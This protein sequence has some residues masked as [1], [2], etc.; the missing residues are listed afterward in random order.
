[1]LLIVYQ[2]LQLRISRTHSSIEEDIRAT[3]FLLRSAIVTRDA[4][5]FST[6]TSEADDQWL[7]EQTQLLERG[8]ILDRPLMGLFVLDDPPDIKEINI[9]DDRRSAQ[10][11]VEDRYRVG[12]AELAQELVVLQR[13]D[14][15]RW[16]KGWLWAPPPDDYWGKRINHS[17]SDQQLTVE[18][19][20]RD[21]DLVLRLISDLEILFNELCNTEAYVDCS[22]VYPFQLELSQDTGRFLELS[23]HFSKNGSAVE[24]DI[25]R[26]YGLSIVLP[27]PTLIG[28]PI[29]DSGYQALLRTYGIHLASALLSAAGKYECCDSVEEFNAARQVFLSDHD[30]LVWPDLE[31][32]PLPPSFQL[33][34]SSV[35]VMCSSGFDSGAA[36][37][38]YDPISGHWVL[39]GRHP[40]DGI[41]RS[42]PGGNGYVVQ[43][44]QPSGDGIITRL[45]F[46]E[47]EKERVLFNR[48]LSPRVAEGF[49]WAV[50]ENSD[51]LITRIPNENLG[52]ANYITSDLICEM[53]ECQ[54]TEIELQGYPL[55]SP[56]DENLIVRGY[57]MFWLHTGVGHQ[58]IAQQ[59]F[60]QAPFWIDDETFGYVR[61]NTGVRWEVA[62]SSI[63]SDSHQ[64]AFNSNDSEAL[65]PDEQK[66]ARVSIALIMPARE[67]ED[68]WWV[69]AIAQPYREAKEIVNIYKYDMVDKI[70]EL[71]SGSV[72]LNGVNLS[73]DG[74]ILAGRI[75][76]D[77]ANSWHYEIFGLSEGLLG[78]VYLG[79]NG[80][81]SNKPTS[82]WSSDGRT[83]MVLESGQLTF[84]GLESGEKHVVLP[85]QPGC[86]QS[87]WV[88]GP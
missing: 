38:R 26:T 51:T 85:P 37:Y 1:M 45:L 84:F 76:N 36:R 67:H 59:S 5:L 39:L 65:L 72:A 61:S 70:L 64:I 18:Y 77:E 87:T 62:Y 47:G 10:V 58:T 30:L 25:D 74:V 23:E 53:H 9:S 50:D 86:Y 81:Q 14:T 19:P 22:S 68:Q 83:L 20:D 33:A 54:T 63:L 13:T 42:A 48:I 79:E 56:D 34:S 15:F 41:V 32:E 6:L 7:E 46:Y 73:D 60:G 80:T 11:V 44:S 52:L 35:D 78:T 69:I 17:S 82:D 28:L 55:W 16:D 43:E 31:P 66:P 49:V 88:T 27:A 3:Y 75:F 21:S 29:S 24:A 71:V 40:G 57:R 2:Q 12:D 4:E 8:W